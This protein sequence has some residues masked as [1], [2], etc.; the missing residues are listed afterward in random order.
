LD[1]GVQHVHI[2]HLIDGNNVV[3]KEDNLSIVK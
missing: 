3:R 2:I 1:L